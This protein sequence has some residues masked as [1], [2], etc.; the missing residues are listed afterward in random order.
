ML[1]YCESCELDWIHI[2]FSTFV[3]LSVETK[4]PT[5]LSQKNLIPMK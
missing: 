3:S 2:F 1:I 5:Q 4:P